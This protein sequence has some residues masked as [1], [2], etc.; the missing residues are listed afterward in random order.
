[1]VMIEVARLN[2]DTP[3]SPGSIS[4][5]ESSR[6]NSLMLAHLAQNSEPATSDSSFHLTRKRA[7][8]ID[9][10][11]ANYPQIGDLALRS[12]SSNEPPTSD[13]TREQVC[14]CQPDPKIPRPRNGA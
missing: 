12:T 13:L 6:Q 14:L 9:T 5:S 3:R 8:S 2:T 7:A 1:M 11:S 10:S 4:T